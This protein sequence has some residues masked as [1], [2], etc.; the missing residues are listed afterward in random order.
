M[1]HR[2]IVDI[3]I[4]A[5]TENNNLCEELKVM[6]FQTTGTASEYFVS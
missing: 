6:G 2:Y 1:S 4:H 5:V 3:V